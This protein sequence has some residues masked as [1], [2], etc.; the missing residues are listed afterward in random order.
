[1]ASKV[2]LDVTERL[3]ITCKKGDT[4][5]LTLTIKDASG[6]AKT[7]VTSGF[8]FLMQVKQ[9]ARARGRERKLILGSTSIGRVQEDGRNF[10]FTKDDSGNLTIT[11]TSAVMSEIDAGRYVYDIQQTVSDVTTTILEGRFVVN[12]DISKTE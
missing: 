2:N 10:T 9:P 5:S 12:D 8:D 11:A 4:F 1:M 3:D 6:T 7:L